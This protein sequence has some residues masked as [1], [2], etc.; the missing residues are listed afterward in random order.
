MN[1]IHQAA[2]FV[3]LIDRRLKS[4]VQLIYVIVQVRVAFAELRLVVIADGPLGVG[5]LSGVR[6]IVQFHAAAQVRGFVF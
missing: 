5:V 2:V 1:R 6:H 4:P 3:L